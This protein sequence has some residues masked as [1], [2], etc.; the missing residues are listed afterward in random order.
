MTTFETYV[1]ANFP[2][3]SDSAKRAARFQY[4]QLRELSD[5]TSTDIPAMAQR[6][7]D[8]LEAVRASHDAKEGELFAVAF[9]NDRR[10]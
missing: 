8:S 6:Y 3:A 7:A 9:E 2:F 1:D 4:M 10:K 5:L